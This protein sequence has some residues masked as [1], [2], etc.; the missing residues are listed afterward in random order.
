M[1]VLMFLL[2]GGL[3]QIMFLF[4]FRFF[5][6]L[7]LNSRSAVCPEVLSAFSYS[8]LALLKISSFAELSDNLWLTDVGIWTQAYTEMMV[9]SFYEIA[10]DRQLTE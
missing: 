10:M 4:L 3:N 2:K 1:F 6:Q 7:G 8:V 5:G 9:S